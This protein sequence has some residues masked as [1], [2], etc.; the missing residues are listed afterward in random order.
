MA[1]KS[2][3]RQTFIAA[4]FFGVLAFGQLA[5]IAVPEAA[6]AGEY[7]TAE[8]QDEYYGKR[9]V[10]TVALSD[11]HY[12][13]DVRL[14]RISGGEMIPLD[15]PEVKR[16]GFTAS[17]DLRLPPGMYTVEADLLSDGGKVDEYAH[18]F[19]LEGIPLNLYLFGADE[20]TEPVLYQD[21]YTNDGDVPL[22]ITPVSSE[23][24]NGYRKYAFMAYP[25]ACYELY[26]DGELRYYEICNHWQ[27]DYVYHAD[28]ADYE[29]KFF[30]VDVDVD[31]YGV[32]SGYISIG[33]A[34]YPYRLTAADSA[35]NRYVCQEEAATETYG[36]P[37]FEFV[38]Q[39]PFA[40]DRLIV[41]A[42]DGGRYHE[43]NGVVMLGNVEIGGIELEDANPEA[44]YGAFT[45]RF[46]PESEPS[47][48]AMYRIT[49]TIQ[50][51]WDVSWYVPANGGGPYSVS[52]SDA[53]LY[54]DDLIH[55]TPISSSGYPYM[56]PTAVPLVDDISALPAHQLD[57]DDPSCP[58]YY[59]EPVYLLYDG[60]D[61]EP[62]DVAFAS[63]KL[64]WT[65][66]GL[67]EN[68]RIVAYDLFFADGDMKIFQAHV[69]VHQPEGKET[70]EYGLKRI[71]GEAA[72]V[73][74]VT[75]IE[76]NTGGGY[77]RSSFTRPLYIKLP[78][79]LT[80]LRVNGFDA[81]PDAS[82][83]YRFRAYVARDA[84]VAMIEAWSTEGAILVDDQPP[85]QDGRWTV[86]I[87]GEQRDIVIQVLDHDA[88]SSMNYV[89]T[90]VRRK[91]GNAL[92]MSSIY[93]DLGDGT[94]G[95]L[96]RSATVYDMLGGFDVAPGTEKIA[97]GPD[98]RAPGGNGEVA[99][100]SK[101]V[102]VTPDGAQYEI[103][104][105]FLSELL[106]EQ[107]Q[108]GE[109]VTIGMIAK[110]VVGQLH[111]DSSE[112]IDLTGDG[113]FDR[114]DVRVVLKELEG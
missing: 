26:I 47:N 44:D 109:S 99:P 108:G 89:L 22:N 105:R 15:A 19:A 75:L 63:G 34:D 98:G 57:F 62:E 86:G 81:V 50:D 21:V 28:K 112:R 95:Y 13:L 60:Y 66:P 23:P 111:E 61:H 25:E 83:P 78:A 32:I 4:L 7:L 10:W 37:Y 88:S 101:L 53:K 58:V 9:F 29:V 87:G 49:S 31:P 36:F 85:G 110:F 48:V 6:A 79:G 76:E 24:G 90:L 8:V 51:H 45:L 82:D 70:F 38:C 84:D 41:E 104:L 40:A 69:R 100:G 67:E 68:F 92:V 16:S 73:A 30:T 18:T 55:I 102:L 106:L 17:L 2:G 14:Y 80:A 77:Y 64:S 97:I 33:Y 59:C 107:E 96:P 12:E 27:S 46:Q 94:F 103:G 114:D 39:P 113:K 43:T 20:T 5:G 91:P 72:Y 35:G 65:V 42:L 1:G 54:T 52:L 93:R 71:P 56:K 74:V 3:L 11:E